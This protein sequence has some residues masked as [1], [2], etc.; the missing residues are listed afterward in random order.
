MWDFNEAVSANVAQLLTDAATMLQQGAV[1]NFGLAAHA[2]LLKASLPAHTCP[3]LRN[4]SLSQLY[5]C[6]SMLPFLKSSGLLP[7]LIGNREYF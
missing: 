5:K 2:A 1:M 3:A 7:G 4:P 6:C